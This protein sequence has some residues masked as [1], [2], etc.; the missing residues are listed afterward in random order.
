MSCGVMG[1]AGDTK[2]DEAPIQEPKDVMHMR[3]LRCET[4]LERA[5]LGLKALRVASEPQREGGAEKG[6]D[7]ESSEF[8]REGSAMRWILLA[9]APKPSLPICSVR[10]AVVIHTAIA[11][12]A[13]RRVT[14]GASIYGNQPTCSNMSAAAHINLVSLASPIPSFSIASYPHIVQAL[15]TEPA[16][17]PLNRILSS[18]DS[19]SNLDL[20]NVIEFKSFLMLDLHW[21]ISLATF[22]LYKGKLDEWLRLIFF[23]LQDRPPIFHQRSSASSTH[24]P[25]SFTVPSSPSRSSP[26]ISFHNHPVSKRL[27]PTLMDV[28]TF[29]ISLIALN[30]VRCI[31]LGGANS[32][33]D[34]LRLTLSR[35][36]WTP[37][38]PLVSFW[39][40]L[41]KHHSEFEFPADID[42]ELATPLSADGVTR[43]LRDLRSLTFSSA[44]P[45]DSLLPPMSLSVRGIG[46]H[47]ASVF[48]RL[49]IDGVQDCREVATSALEGLVGGLHLS[50]VGTV[51]DDGFFQELENGLEDLGLI[52]TW[53][54][55]IE[56]VCRD[57][58]SAL[59]LQP[60]VSPTKVN[61]PVKSPQKH[62]IIANPLFDE[63][64]KQERS[65]SRQAT[66]NASL[67]RSLFSPAKAAAAAN[68]N[69]SSP[70]SRKHEMSKSSPFAKSLL[71]SPEQTQGSPSSI[72]SALSS[73]TRSTK[74]QSLYQKT[75]SDSIHLPP[76][77]LSDG[78]QNPADHT[79]ELE[80]NSR[81]NPNDDLSEDAVPP[82]VDLSQ[83]LHESNLAHQQNVREEKAQMARAAE[84]NFRRGSAG[85]GLNGGGPIAPS[86]IGGSKL[87]GG[88]FLLGNAGVANDSV[89][90]LNREKENSSNSGVLEDLRLWKFTARAQGALEDR[91]DPLLSV[92]VPQGVISGDDS[93]AEFEQDLDVSIA[94]DILAESSFVADDGTFPN[95]GEGRAPSRRDRLFAKLDGK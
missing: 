56:K 75:P 17:A 76:T 25:A 27:I 72:S 19:E 58:H 82:T 62:F 28:E 39:M 65:M 36:C 30:Y 22:H 20:W 16:L 12:M 8:E 15:N 1:R 53:T 55:G 61:T 79:V 83:L 41:L 26:S 48:S 11:I 45:A 84:L 31:A 64:A 89:E 9:A 85:G 24:R 42:F 7:L 34:V 3:K 73:P 54:D 47:V 91:K 10:I 68:Y 5:V 52:P 74:S 38:Q 35:S 49:A 86:S 95:I 4:A 80:A 13:S 32:L 37:S 66:V 51:E 70:L 44:A 81:M 23:R 60:P 67:Q 18:M 14:F 71:R 2:G 57:F 77:L 63:Y 90:V 59:A 94:S 93:W 21:F 87:F 92:P 50:E 46:M 40:A 29:V 88:G 78:L 33:G 69:A 6:K 43:F